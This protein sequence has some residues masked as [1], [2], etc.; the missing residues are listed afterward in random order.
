MKLDTYILWVGGQ[1]FS[2]TDFWISARVPRG[3]T[4]NLEWSGDDPPR[5][6]C[7]LSFYF[8][9]SF[10]SEKIIIM[11]SICHNYMDKHPSRGR[12]LL[13]EVSSGCP[14]AAQRPKFKIP[15]PRSRVPR[16]TEYTCQVS[17]TSTQRYRSLGF[18]NCW[19]RNDGRTDGHLTGFIAARCY[20]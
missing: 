11:D 3:A 4:P 16:R 13:T 18:R 17:L 2:K 14:C 5:S 1:N 9:F 12:S 8:T 19:H 10:L 7:L 20:A 6:G 15:L